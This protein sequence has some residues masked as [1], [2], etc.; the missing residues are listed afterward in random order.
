MERDVQE[1]TPGQDSRK[2]QQP[3]HMQFADMR[4]NRAGEDEIKAVIAKRQMWDGG[5]GGKEQWGM[6]V[7]HRPSDLVRLD[8]DPPNLPTL[9]SFGEPPDHLAVRATELEYP[10]TGAPVKSTL[11]EC[12]EHRVNVLAS[13][14]QVTVARLAVLH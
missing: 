4:E 14:Y 9:S 5:R 3:G 6:E 1:A 2:L 7:F 10:M 11:I 8:V 13:R 12:G